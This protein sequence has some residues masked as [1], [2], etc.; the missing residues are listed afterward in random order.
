MVLW[1]HRVD[2]LKPSNKVLMKIFE[3]LV[4]LGAFSCHQQQN[5]HFL[6]QIKNIQVKAKALPTV[7][8]VRTY[9][10]MVMKN[11]FLFLQRIFFSSFF[12][13]LVF[14]FSFSLYWPNSLRWSFSFPTFF[15]YL[16][17][18]PNAYKFLSL[19]LNFYAPFFS[20][21]SSYISHLSW[22]LLVLPVSP[23]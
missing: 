9:Y 15:F 21:Y 17:L 11:N 10:G 13:L 2:K 14:L 4:I 18:S 12:F 20:I 1:R 5:E 6:S 16:I 8:S 22:S 3:Q 23:C 7:I 19:S